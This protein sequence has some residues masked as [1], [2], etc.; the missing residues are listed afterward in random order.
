MVNLYPN[1]VNDVAYISLRHQHGEEYTSKQIS[2]AE[3]LTLQGNMVLSKDFNAMEEIRIDMPIDFKG[4][5]I[6]KIVDSEGK[7]YIRKMAV[8]S[9]GY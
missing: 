7:V 6:L 3:V 1:P 5:Y 4:L 9:K 8:R 2:H